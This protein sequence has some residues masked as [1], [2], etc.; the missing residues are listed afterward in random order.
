MKASALMASN[1]LNFNSILELSRFMIA[2]R[3]LGSELN[4]DDI[5]FLA[6]SAGCGS[7]EEEDAKDGGDEKVKTRFISFQAFLRS[8]RKSLPEVNE[9][10]QERSKFLTELENKDVF[11]D[12]DSECSE[13]ID[14]AVVE[15]QRLEEER[16]RKEAL[17]LKCTEYDHVEIDSFDGVEDGYDEPTVIEEVNPD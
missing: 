2:L 16:I 3:Y 6:N 15:A 7:I 17:F 9:L 1:E 12:L 8:L 13:E 5:W 11:N 10:F 4:Q 14:D